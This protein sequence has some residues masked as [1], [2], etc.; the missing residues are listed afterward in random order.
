MKSFCKI[1]QMSKGNSFLKIYVL[2]GIER[3]LKY[4]KENPLTQRYSIESSESELVIED[5]LENLKVNKYNMI[6]EDG[7]KNEFT[8]NIIIVN[9]KET[10][11][12]ISSTKP[13]L[14]KFK[15][16]YG[17]YK[18]YGVLFVYAAVENAT[19]AYNGPELLKRIKENKKALVLDN[20]NTVK[21]F[22]IPAN[23]I[24]AFSKEILSDEGYWINGTE[25]QK[26]KLLST[27][28]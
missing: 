2:D 6:S 27:E 9:S 5:V 15:E 11:E 10:M 12:Y 19:V 17:S 7:N 26:V 18:N 16:I 21:I 20:I 23:Q 4:L 28:G 13:V 14:E 24:R 22:D 1:M 3:E 25:V 8:T